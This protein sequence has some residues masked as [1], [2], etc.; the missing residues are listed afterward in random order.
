MGRAETT[1]LIKINL[2]ALVNH[3]PP[4]ETIL[5]LI[6]E[7]TSNHREGGLGPRVKGKP[8]YLIF[9]HLSNPGKPKE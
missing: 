2:P 3:W 9:S 4:H 6:L 8:K 7:I 1:T 5:D